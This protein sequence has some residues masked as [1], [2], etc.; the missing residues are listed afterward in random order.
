M[1]GD[2]VVKYEPLVSIVIVTYNSEEYVIETLNSCINQN[3]KNFE[4]II[5]DDG[6]T[7]KTLDLCE[8]WR[9][10]QAHKYAIKIIT[11]NLRKG[12][13]ANC[14]RGANVSKGEWIKFLGADDLLEPDAIEN[15]VKAGSKGFD[16]V[17]SKFKTFGSA[18]TQSEIYPYYF[19]WRL[20]KCREFKWTKFNEWLFLLGFSNV[21]PGAFIK[22]STF[23]ALHKYNEDYY[24]L[25]DLPLWHKAFNSKYKITTCNMITVNYRVHQKQVTSNGLSP[26]LKKDLLHF[27]ETVRKGSFIPYYHNLF[28]IKVLS[29]NL[30]YKF[31]FF[32]VFQIVI[33]IINRLGK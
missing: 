17:Y 20:I 2:D 7:D 28:Q 6:S 32:D 25:E 9:C 14:N 31:R 15:L 12:I 29:S 33:Y 5:S 11:S 26:L 8:T 27:N 30:Y 23:N 18:I 1:P 16:L 4:I 21:A 3:Y 13:P 24:L 22:S 19:T 10:E